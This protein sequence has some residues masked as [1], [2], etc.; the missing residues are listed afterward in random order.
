MKRKIMKIVFVVMGVLFLT[1]LFFTI[2]VKNAVRA[3]LMVHGVSPVSAFNCNPK[4]SPKTSK[5]LQIP[6]YYVPDKYAYKDGST[7]VHTSTFAIR[8]YLGIFH[9][10]VTADQ[11]FG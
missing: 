2:S 10:A 1:C 3:N 9:V 4:F 11:Y 7:G 6:V 8:T 5:S